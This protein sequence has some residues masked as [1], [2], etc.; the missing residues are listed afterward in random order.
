MRSLCATKIWLGAALL[1]VATGMTGCTTEPACFRDCVEEAPSATGGSAGTGGLETGGSFMLGTGGD[2]DPGTGN[3][4]SGGG[5]A[6]GG[7]GSDCEGVDLKTDPNNCGECG[8]PCLITG[9]DAA[10]VNGKC[11]LEQCRPGRY[12]LNG[13][14]GDGCEYAC[15]GDP[16][17]DE[18]CNFEDDDCD[19][20]KD[21]GFD[22]DSDPET[23]GSCK[24]CDLLHATAKCEVGVCKV[25]ECEPG[26]F[27]IGDDDASGCNYPCQYRDKNKAVC[28]PPAAG[29]PNPNGCGV[30]VCD[31]VDQDCDGDFGDVEDENSACSDF[32]F[33]DSCEGECSFGTTQCIGSVLVCIPGK[34]PTAEVCDGKD[35]D[36]NGTPDDGFELDTNTENCGACGNSCVGKLPHAFGKC[37]N[38]AC[39][40]DLCET[41]Y[42][43]YD[44]TK[45]GCELCPVTPVRPESCNGKDDDC[46]GVVDDGTLTPPAT[47]AS[48]GVNSF[49]KQRSGTLCDN[50][51]IRCD[52]AA[53]GWVCDYPEHVETAAGKVVITESLCDGW[54]GNCDGQKDEAFLDLGKTCN[55]GKLGVCLDFGKIACSPTDATKTFCNISLPPNPPASSAEVCNGLDDDC[56]GD[57]DEGTDEMVRIKRNGLDFF[58]DVYEASRP[59][60]TDSAVGTD[61]T[62]RCGV[63]DRL[64]WTNASFDEASEACLAS[65]KRLC[66]IKELEE[67]CEGLNNDAYPYGNAY[68]LATCNGADAPGSA[69]APTGS[70]MSCFSDDGVYD[71]SG[72]VSEWSDS[73]QGATT[74][75]PKY[76]IMSLHGGSFLTPQNGLTCK[77]DFDVISTNAVLPSLGFRCCDDP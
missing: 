47:G 9:A 13:K 22:L 62:H 53:G 14:V 59:D 2:D 6:A 37:V 36:C 55:D 65:G 12:D 24:P 43:D 58:I 64:P 50:V 27:K 3:K 76:D 31:D 25:D 74:G 70:F 57:I 34:T 11:T 21:E 69:A 46:N 40:I 44:K 20:L 68:V 4:P 10:C 45:A 35:N 72:N 39:V 30:E 51:P 49:C 67:A 52:K 28:T 29:Q 54:D 17:N 71:L 32:C 38:S 33:N 8:N 16:T 26:F 1:S 75:T 61:E 66:H 42:G 23:C 48:A 41:D 77:F 73:K 5:P 18:T 15:D 60:A 7:A 56:D 63:A 19:G